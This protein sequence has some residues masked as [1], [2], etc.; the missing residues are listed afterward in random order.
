M[1]R[2]AIAF[3]LSGCAAERAVPYLDT[4]DDD[5]CRVLYDCHDYCGNTPQSCLGHDYLCHCPSSVRCIQHETGAPPPYD[6]LDLCE[7]DAAATLER[8]P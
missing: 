6:Y 1:I 7:G 3:A 8:A 5:T 2:L 4:S